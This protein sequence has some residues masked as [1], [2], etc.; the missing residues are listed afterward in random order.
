ML[1]YVDDTNT[2]LSTD[3]VMFTMP[4]QGVVSASVILQNVG[5]NTL[6]YHFQ[7]FDGANW[8]EMTTIGN[9]LYNTLVAG[10]T[11]QVLVV[12]IYPQVRLMSSASGGSTIGFSVTRYFNRSSGG[13]VPLISGF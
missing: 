10:Q 1:T 4:Q 3:S 8:D 2:V 11:T 9:P 5:T 7:Q 6:T 12:S 13:S